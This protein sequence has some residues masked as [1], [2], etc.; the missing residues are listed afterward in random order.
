M[1]TTSYHCLNKIIEDDSESIL[2]TKTDEA[3]LFPNLSHRL[4]GYKQWL[5]HNDFSY[6]KLELYIPIE[7]ASSI[8]DS[9]L[10]NSFILKIPE[11]LSLT[12]GRI[13]QPTF[14]HCDLFHSSTK[15]MLN[16][17]TKIQKNTKHKSSLCTLMMLCWATFRYTWTCGGLQVDRYLW[18]WGRGSVG[19]R[20]AN[21]Q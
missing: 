1:Q 20:L 4:T 14:W 3:S 2:Y 11:L 12:A 18:G 10:Y 9:I 19:K 16:S 5:I 15:F 6:L 8:Q 13:D 21:L 17:C 7:F